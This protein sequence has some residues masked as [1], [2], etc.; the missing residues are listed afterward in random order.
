MIAY[1]I[2]LSSAKIISTI[3]CLDVDD[4]DGN[5]SENRKTERT[6]NKGC[7][8]RRRGEILEEGGFFCLERQITFLGYL[9]LI[10]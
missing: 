4:V 3:N 5:C 1:V 9:F 6:R 7:Q 2:E 10:L 8:K